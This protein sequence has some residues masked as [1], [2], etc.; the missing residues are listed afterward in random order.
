MTNFV[1]SKS[2]RPGKKYMV[3]LRDG[4]R[5]KTVHFG[6]AGMSDY[7]K[8][9]DPARK[10]R[11]L[12]RHRK[13]EN[14]T[15]SGRFTAGFW[16]RWVLWNEPSLSGS[17]ASLKRKFS[18]LKGG[19]KKLSEKYVPKSLTAKDRAAQIKSIRKGNLRPKVKSFKSR[20]SSWASKFEKKYGT[21]ITDKA[22][23]GRKILKRKG[24]DK[25]LAKGK[26]AYFSSGSRPNQTPSSWAYAR[27]ASV[28]MNGPA[29]RY[30]KK[31]WDEY[32]I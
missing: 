29:R 7:T 24:I 5:K 31:I 32:K 4:D 17:L 22:F 6:A 25:I 13:R 16:S 8:H 18:N 23:I 12:A 10:D 2:S 14:W 28:I 26:G 20:R 27:L 3:V 1:L 19:G 21:K 15:Y 30:D 11:Y 9:K